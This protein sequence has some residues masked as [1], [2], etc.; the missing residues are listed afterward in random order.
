MII[1]T[2]TNW[3]ACCVGNVTCVLVSTIHC[4]CLSVS[5]VTTQGVVT[6]CRRTSVPT[7]KTTVTLEE[8]RS[9]L[10]KFF[11]VGNLDWSASSS[12]NRIC[13]KY[14][15][16]LN[17]F[18]QWDLIATTKGRSSAE[19]ALQTMMQ[20]GRQAAIDRVVTAFL[21][22][23]AVLG[24]GANLEMALASSLL[25]WLMRLESNEDAMKTAEDVN[26]EDASGLRSRRRS[27]G[28]DDDDDFITIEV[29]RE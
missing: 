19:W 15:L 1:I 27:Y 16:A 24:P 29:A 20:T 28:D 2:I 25:E 17:R 12:D 3:G 7:N 26:D 10:A 4:V 18:L 6:K 11:D 13:S 8:S 22:M 21:C 23:R 9:D 5:G 14:Q